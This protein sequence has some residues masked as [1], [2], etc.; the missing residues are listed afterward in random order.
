MHGYRLPVLDLKIAEVG[1]STFKCVLH[2]D[3]YDNCA[4][5]V[6]KLE[7]YFEF[8]SS[9]SKKKTTVHRYYATPLRNTKRSDF[10]LA[11]RQ[12]KRRR[13]NLSCKKCRSSTLKALSKY[14]VVYRFETKKREFEVG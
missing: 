10:Y 4:C 14:S 7:R 9:S 3:R 8:P 2:S 6:Y 12:E 1:I 5:Q 13:E 11:T